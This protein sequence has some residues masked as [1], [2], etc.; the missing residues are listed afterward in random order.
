M[1]KSVLF[2]YI[3]IFVMYVKRKFHK[4]YELYIDISK[5]RH[6]SNILDSLLAERDFSIR[7]CNSLIMFY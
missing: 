4:S 7:A 2:L 3:T 1:K 6:F 5:A